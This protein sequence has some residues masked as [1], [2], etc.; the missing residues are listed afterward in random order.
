MPAIRQTRRELSWGCRGRTKHDEG[1]PPRI[2]SVQRTSIPVR[3]T[4]WTHGG[5]AR[6]GRD[7][8]DVFHILAVLRGTYRTRRIITRREETSR[9]SPRP[10]SPL[11]AGLASPAPLAPPPASSPGI[12]VYA[13]LALP[14]YS[15]NSARQVRLTQRGARGMQA[16]A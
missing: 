12:Y 4:E 13:S 15:A 11:P 10:P 1:I 7:R 16:K 9:C 6:N 8:H 14:T 5:G 3:I 2:V